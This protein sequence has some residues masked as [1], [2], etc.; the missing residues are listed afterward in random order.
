MDRV[1][2][3][4]VIRTKVYDDYIKRGT[5]VMEYHRAVDRGGGGLAVVVAQAAFV[6]VVQVATSLPPA[7]VL[8]AP[9]LCLSLAFCGLNANRDRAT[10]LPPLPLAAT[11]RASLAPTPGALADWAPVPDDGHRASDINLMKTSTDK[12]NV[13]GATKRLD[14]DQG[15]RIQACDRLSTP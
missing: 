12:T 3:T 2:R 9:P 5:D 1:T 7:T 8:P 10:V 11:R 6:S 13:L 15:T 14:T 4:E